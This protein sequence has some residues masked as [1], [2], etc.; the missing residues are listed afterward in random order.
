MHATLCDLMTDLVQNSIEARAT[1]INLNIEE[2]DT[3]LRFVITDNGKGMNAETLEKAKDPF[4]SDGQKHRHRNVGLGLPFLFQ[5][6]EMTGGTAVIDSKEGT[7]TVVTFNVDPT[8]VDLPQFG[9]FTTAAVTLMTY[10]FEG[11]L[12]IE[13]NVNGK[14]YAVSKN[15][16]IDALG[17]LNN[18]GN[19]VLL[20]EFIASREEDLGA[21]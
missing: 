17:D 16:L 4:Y 6:A 18:T 13:R 10:G 14:G 11:N 9:N 1:E 8:H 20:K 5:T 21:I 2:T 19:L 7:G 3:N 15:E 12:K